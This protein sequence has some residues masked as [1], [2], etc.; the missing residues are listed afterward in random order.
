MVARFGWVPGRVEC[1]LTTRGVRVEQVGENPLWR[2]VAMVGVAKRSKQFGRQPLSWSNLVGAPARGDIIHCAVARLPRPQTVEFGSYVR[3]AR[4][5]LSCRNRWEAC[6]SQ[7]PVNSRSASGSSAQELRVKTCRKLGQSTRGS[8]KQTREELA[9]VPVAAHLRRGR[10][11]SKGRGRVGLIGGRRLGPGK[12]V[13]WE[14]YPWKGSW[15]SQASPVLFR[16]CEGAR[17]GTSAHTRHLGTC[18]G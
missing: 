8:D 11:A 7:A 15:L 3:C 6:G 16:V 2:A 17:Q 14:R 5:S 12:R 10:S 9:E 18:Q 1:L 4:G 13:A